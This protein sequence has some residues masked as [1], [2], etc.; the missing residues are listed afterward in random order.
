M[1]KLLNILTYE[2]YI[3]IFFKYFDIYK[4]F[5]TMHG[6]FQV[7]SESSTLKI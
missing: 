3:A 6:P 7:M 2:T 1:R 5:D 4:F